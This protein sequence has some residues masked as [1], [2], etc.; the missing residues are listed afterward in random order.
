MVT[1]TE[2]DGML[3]VS[4]RTYEH[5]ERIKIE[6]SGR[7]DPKNK[8]WV[9]ENTPQNKKILK[10]LKM[11]R[12]CGWCGEHGH[13]KTKCKVYREHR[14]KEKIAKYK[15]MKP[16]LGYMRFSDRPTCECGVKTIRDTFLDIDLEYKKT[17]W[18]CENYC[19][20]RA[21]DCEI[22]SKLLNFGN[23]N[24]RCEIHG[25]YQMRKHMEFMNDTSGT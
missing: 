11:K 9:V 23:R 8:V 16:A 25:T 21:I 14:I 4:G 7:W 17:C 18:M 12:N 19:C 15:Q 5:R 22:D 3:H 24:C 6:C 1:I 2:Q 13:F 20:S 10:G